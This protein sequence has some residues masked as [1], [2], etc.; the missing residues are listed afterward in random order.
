MPDESDAVIGPAS[1]RPSGRDAIKPRHSWLEPPHHI[2]CPDL[3]ADN[4]KA[5]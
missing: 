1:A 3:N 4:V 5:L 2:E